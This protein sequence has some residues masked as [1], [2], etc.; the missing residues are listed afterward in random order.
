MCIVVYADLKVKALS[1]RIKFLLDSEP[2]SK[3][4][5]CGLGYLD[6]N[7]SLNIWD[8]IAEDWSMIQ[9]SVISNHPVDRLI[10]VMHNSWSSFVS[11]LLSGCLTLYIILYV[12]MRSTHTTASHDNFSWF[13][14]WGDL[15][16]SRFQ[17]QFCTCSAHLG[18]KR[19][20][21]SLFN[22][23]M[24]AALLFVTTL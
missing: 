23:K 1:N 7:T 21:G 9:T 16:L 10:K 14:C 24:P 19:E 22:A 11:I 20:S 5:F 8:V 2:L 6:S 18:K 15:I 3:I 17:N 12:P 13:S 4:I